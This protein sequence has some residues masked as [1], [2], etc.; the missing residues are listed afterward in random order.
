MRLL[1]ALFFIV[2]SVAAETEAPAQASPP[3]PTAPKVWVKSEILPENFTWQDLGL[4]KE[5]SF[6]GPIAEAWKKFLKEK[7]PA[8]ISDVE[9][10]TGPC[11][12]YLEEWEAKTPKLVRSQPVETYAGGYWL[13][14]SIRMWKKAE[15]TDASAFHWEGRAVLMDINTKRHLGTYPLLREEKAFEQ[16]GQLL[17]S[18]LG[19]RIYRTPLGALQQVAGVLAKGASKKEVLSLKVK[20]H[21]RLLDVMD[22]MRLLE[23]R[24]THLALS[25]TL[26]GF[27]GGEATLIGYYQGEEKSFTD[28][29]SQV[30]ELKSS[31]S[32]DLVPKSQGSDH[33][34]QLVTK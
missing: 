20:G 1:L 12:A 10:C 15:V 18:A 22:L 2:T 33:E 28:L 3:A 31:E 9:L 32:Y 5:E 14:V 7:L 26:E 25:F 6:T 30:K 4:T 34:I 17:N 24:G 11:A 21:K 23:T 27:S 13:K 16:A 19:N 8:T 29:L